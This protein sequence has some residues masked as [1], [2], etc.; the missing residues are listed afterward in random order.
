MGKT[1]GFLEYERKNG[2]VV[3]EADRVKD[4][5][6]FHGSLP[7]EEQQKQVYDPQDPYNAIAFKLPD[8]L[9]GIWR[10]PDDRNEKVR[11]IL[12]K[13]LY[14]SV[15]GD[16]H[17]SKHVLKIVDRLGYAFCPEQYPAANHE[18]HSINMFQQMAPA[19]FVIDIISGIFLE[20]QQ[21]EIHQAPAY[22]R[23]VRAMP[24][25]CT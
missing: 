24:D 21:Y 23:P 8:Q 7:I 1:T 10:T 25:P 5:Q 4:F 14:E 2:P 22:E 11:G 6:E 9:F 16:R 18:E 13:I 17:P 20:Y 12:S 3:E 19:F 15:V